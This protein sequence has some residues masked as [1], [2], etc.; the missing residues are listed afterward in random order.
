M[1]AMMMSMS[2][3]KSH[4]YGLT[5]VEPNEVET[6]GGWKQVWEHPS[7]LRAVRHPVTG[8]WHVSNGSEIIS[9]R[10][11]FSSSLRAAAMKIDRLTS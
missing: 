9:D 6:I 2:Y 4:R 1:N 5:H 11:S 8:R 3:L 10:Y 7:G